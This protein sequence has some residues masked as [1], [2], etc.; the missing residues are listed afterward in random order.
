MRS[1]VKSWL[2]NTY[3]QF[4]IVISPLRDKNSRCLSIPFMNVA[5]E[6][7]ETT[8]IQVTDEHLHDQQK[9]EEWPVLF[10]LKKGQHGGFISQKA[11]PY[12]LI[13]LTCWSLRLQGVLKYQALITNGCQA[14]FYHVYND[15]ISP[16]ACSGHS[17]ALEYVD[18]T[19]IAGEKQKHWSM[20]KASGQSEL[21]WKLFWFIFVQQRKLHFQTVA[22]WVGSLR[23]EKASLKSPVVLHDQLTKCCC[24]NRKT[25]RDGETLKS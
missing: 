22:C 10:V 11:S 23:F 16:G 14:H 18:T 24:N 7:P 21:W 13:L 25:N 3:Q 6:T 17:E 2:T 1:A 12:S 20:G 15:Y 8:G 5:N 19:L 4:L 9:V